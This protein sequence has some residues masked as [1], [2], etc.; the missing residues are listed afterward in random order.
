MRGTYY[1]VTVS[2]Y[3]PATKQTEYD[4]ERRI[5]WV[6]V[7]GTYD[8]FFNDV[9]IRGS[10]NKLDEYI[11]KVTKYDLK[12][13]V[14]YDEKYVLGY[15][16]ERSSLDLVEGFTRAKNVMQNHLRYLI[17]LQ[18][19]GDEVSNL[20]IDTNYQDITF[21]QLLCPIYLA[22]YKV[23]GKKN[24]YYYVINGENGNAYGDYPMSTAKILSI[25]FSI[26]AFI[27][28]LILAIYFAT[29]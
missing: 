19:G 5:N 16:A 23:K 2:R 10:E 9:V 27:L 24:Y 7:H 26:L 15:R 20:K 12:K 25:V 6:P 29:R 4:R 8:F 21:K 14:K 22:R 3:N 18:I 28:F 13:V 17:R 11:N 1:Y